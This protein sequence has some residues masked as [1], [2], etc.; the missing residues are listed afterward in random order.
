MRHQFARPIRTAGVAAVLC[1]VIGASL[2]GCT[3]PPKPGTPYL[4]KIYT[5]AKVCTNGTIEGPFVAPGSCNQSGGVD[6]SMQ[7]AGIAAAQ[8]DY[9]AG[10]KDEAKAAA[11]ALGKRK[12]LVD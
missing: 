10:R 7:E 4:D 6:M 2:S 1:V 3:V 8:L 11:R 9:D 5:A 12:L